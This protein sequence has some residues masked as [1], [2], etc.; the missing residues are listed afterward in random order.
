[1]PTVPPAPLRLS[2]TTDSPI[3]SATRAATG[4]E[5][6]SDPP[7]AGNGTIQETVRV[8]QSLARAGATAPAPAAI[9]PPSKLR[10]AIPLIRRG[11]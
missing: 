5:N 11:A 6:M 9:N 4:R 7:P 3:A 1:M 2:I 10:R 8:G